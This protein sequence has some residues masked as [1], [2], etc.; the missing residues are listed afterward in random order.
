MTADSHYR[1][2]GGEI[3]YYSGKVRAY[4]RHKGI[5]FEEQQATREVYK[6][7]ILPRVGWPV[8]PVVVTPDDQTLQDSSDIIDAL[9]QRFPEPSVYPE[10]PCQKLAA[11]LLEVYGDEWL[12]IP[13]MHY[14]WNHNTDWIIREFGRLSR[15][16]GTAEEQYEIGERT[17]RPFRGSLPALGVS[18]STIPAIEASYEALLGDLDAHFAKHPF[19]FGN[20]PSIGDFGL[21]GPLYAH[22]YRDPAS[23]ALMERIAPS[24]VAWVK[25][26]VE[27]AN[28]DT[29]GEF[30]P[31]D[32]VP[33]T[34][35]PVL[36]RM[37]AEQFPVL[38][39]TRTA[40]E[41]WNAAHPEEAI[42]RGI[43]MHGF[44]LQR[45]TPQQA[46]GERA[47]FPFDLWMLQ[48]P[49]DHYRELDGSGRAAADAFMTR[50]G[51]DGALLAPS[52]PT[53]LT[54]VAFRLARA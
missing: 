31:D 13:A 29:K 20:R 33:D 8:I 53:R 2:Y 40:F 50:F 22:Q 26:M 24:V 3:S 54:R 1:L 7:V 16:D 42:P 18:E 27:P 14:R 35:L 9:E 11:L 38:A 49:Q 44:T 21:I 6:E 30:L 39:S 36:A 46:Q 10:G 37:A 17:C 15:P 23:G 28:A 52:N 5:P 4:L 32:D 51:S 41:A 12:K 43:G 19:L 48:R 47:I 45:D 34:L 25:R